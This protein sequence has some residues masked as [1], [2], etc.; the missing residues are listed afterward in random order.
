MVDRL[1]RQ[2]LYRRAVKRI[3]SARVPGVAASAR[4][5]S[6]CNPVWLWLSVSPMRSTR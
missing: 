5:T 1:A 3:P 6:A 2:P 4:R